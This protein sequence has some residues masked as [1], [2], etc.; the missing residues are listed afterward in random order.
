[1]TSARAQLLGVAIA[2]LILAALGVALA[3]LLGASGE[4]NNVVSPLS[5]TATP[6]PTAAVLVLEATNEPV[7]PVATEVIEEPTVEPPV[8]PVSPVPTSTSTPT[9]PTVNEGLLGGLTGLAAAARALE[10]PRMVAILDGFDRETAGLGAA[11]PG[12]EWTV[13]SGRWQTDSGLATL[14][15]DSDVR[16]I[17]VVDVGAIN[18]EVSAQ[19]G[20]VTAKSGLVFRFV[21]ES[22]YWVVLAAPDTPSWNLK[23]VV[24]GEVIDVGNVGV[25]RASDGTN[26]GVRFDGPE[27]EVLVEGRVRAT[28]TDTAHQFG[29]LAGLTA[30][31]PD[32]EGTTWR[33]FVSLAH[34]AA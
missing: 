11:A 1:M 8:V 5:V 17:A 4:S 29:R 22:N 24:G 7:A 23:K 32:A 18:A 30:T 28:F 14:T 33:H 10:E 16:S 9:E 21:D 2:V 15:Q 6:F 13:I 12:Q 19:M 31:G 34:P 3:L 20:T 26:V 25:A 27:I